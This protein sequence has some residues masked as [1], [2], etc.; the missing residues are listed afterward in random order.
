MRHSIVGMQH[1]NSEVAVAAL[2]PGAVVTLVRE[3]TNKF[4]RNAVMVWVDG[5]HVGYVPKATNR[6]LAAMIDAKGR[7]W[8]APAPALAQDEK[9][10]TPVAQMALDAKFARSPNSGYP[11]VETEEHEG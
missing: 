11:Q 1:C 6:A 9:P 7:T 5:V 3:P 10:P 2:Q 8:H 4:D